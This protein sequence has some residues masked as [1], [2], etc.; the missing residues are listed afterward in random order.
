[1][2]VSVLEAEQW[3]D[4]QDVQAPDIIFH[5]VRQ[6]VDDLNAAGFPFGRAKFEQ[7]FGE[8]KDLLNSEVEFQSIKVPAGIAEFGLVLK[9]VPR[10]RPTLRKLIEGHLPTI[11]DLIN[12]VVLTKARE[13]LRENG[14]GEDILLIVDQL[15]RIP[16]L[17]NQRNIYLDHAAILLSLGCHVLYTVPIELAFSEAHL[18]LKAAY[19]CET[20]LLPLIPVSQRDGGTCEEGLRALCRIVHRRIAKTEA[21][22][23]HV[24]EGNVLEQLCGVSGGYIRNLFILLRSAMERCEKLPITRDVADRTIRRQAIDLSLALQPKQREALRAVHRSKEAFNA[25][26]ALWNQLLRNLMALPY[27]DESGVWYDWNPL[28]A[29]VPGGV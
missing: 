11:Y 13:W 23:Q 21:T 8:I 25:D 12:K 14:R 24:F 6:L 15:D 19:S 5:M 20:L 7:F 9:D 28:I 22:P 29:A 10:A 26:P 4:L 16:G 2:F 17:T 18:L 3:L 1:M 27:E